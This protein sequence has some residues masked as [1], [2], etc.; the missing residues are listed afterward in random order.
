MVLRGEVHIR[1][2]GLRKQVRA[3]AFCRRAERA[4]ANPYIGCGICHADVLRSLA[5]PPDEAP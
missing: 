3:F 1:W 2:M 4:V 5:L